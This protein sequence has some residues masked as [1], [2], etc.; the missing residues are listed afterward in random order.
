[1]QTL[2]SFASDNTSGV[3]PRVL[4]ALAAANVGFTP[5]YGEDPYTEKAVA[6]MRERFGVGARPWFVSLGT[7]ANVLGLKAMVRSY[8]GVLCAASAHINTDECGAPEAALGCKLLTVPS[9]R[10]KVDARDC[11][12]YLEQR[13][14]V[15]HSYPRV[16]SISQATEC[17]TVYTMEELTALRN[18]CREQDLYLHMDGARLANAAAALGLS[19]REMTGEAGVD[20]LSFGGTKN[21]LMAAEAVIFFHEALG[22]DFGYIRKQHMQLTSKMRFLSAQFLA[23]FEDDL[24]LANA[25]AANRMAAV[26]AEELGSMEHV[27]IEYPVEVNA[28]FAR[29]SKNAVAKLLE[30]FYFYVLENAGEDDSPGARPLVRLMT[31]FSTTEEEVREFADA[32]RAC[33]D[34]E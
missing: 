15:H 6:A 33:K 29:L 19:L 8:D 32:V 9:L 1:M 25:R 10:G 12:R 24:W 27:S 3:H 34:L 22:R 26:L 20:V 5:A 14:D 2:K 13:G 7:A 11:R 30:R 31:S 28:V 4:A 17:G 21:G 16:L 23:Y 18:F